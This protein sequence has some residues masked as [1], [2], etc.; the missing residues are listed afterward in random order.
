MPAWTPTPTPEPTAL[1]SDL[2][3][4]W[5]EFWYEGEYL[6]NEEKY[7]SDP[8]YHD[9]SFNVWVTI[10]N[11]S[12]ETLPGDVLPVFTLTDGAEERLVTTWYYSMDDQRALEPGEKKE[13]VFR[14]L[15][16]AAN[17]WISRA[18]IRW[19]GQV[20]GKEFPQQ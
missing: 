2:A 9:R 17:Q 18:E 8:V 10:Q 20:W 12:A 14:A 1:P 16:Y 19:R 3:V 4:T 7:P 11:N 5:G 15:T 13:A 6:V